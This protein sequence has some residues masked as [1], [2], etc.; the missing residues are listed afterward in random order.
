MPKPSRRNKQFAPPGALYETPLSYTGTR[1]KQL[2]FIF[3]NNLLN[4]L[5]TPPGEGQGLGD[6]LQGL[7]DPANPREAVVLLPA[8]AEAN[9]RSPGGAATVLRKYQGYFEPHFG[10][11]G[12]QEVGA[13][14]LGKPG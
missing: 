9:Y 11:H 5:A 13:F 8:V 7:R 6:L 3:D 1:F 2:V 4:K 14:S 12:I 10:V